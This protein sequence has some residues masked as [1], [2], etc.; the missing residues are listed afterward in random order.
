M[1]T[2]IVSAIRGPISSVINGWLGGKVAL[3]LGSHSNRH[4]WQRCFPGRCRACK[5]WCVWTLFFFYCSGMVCEQG[6]S[7]KTWA[8]SL[9]GFRLGLWVERDCGH[10]PRCWVRVQGP[11]ESGYLGAI[12]YHIKLTILSKF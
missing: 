9:C 12:Q 7:D 3:Q 6:P 2:V 8:C 1:I 11:N 5:G 10:G 4:A